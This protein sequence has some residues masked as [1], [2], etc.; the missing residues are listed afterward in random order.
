MRESIKRHLAAIQREADKGHIHRM[1]HEEFAKRQAAYDR[2]AQ[3]ILWQRQANL[4]RKYS[5]WS[6]DKPIRFTFEQ[7]DVN[8]QRNA[9]LARDAGNAAYKAAQMIEQD[10]FNLLFTGDPGTG[11]TSLALA[12]AEK[13][14]ADK[15]S[16]YLF[17]STVALA[18]LLT[19]SYRNDF[20][21]SEKLRRLTDHASHTPLL[22]LDDFG[23]EA[24][25]N[26]DGS[27][28]S[29]RND[30]QDWLFNIANARYGQTDSVIITTN[31]TGAELAEMY[32]E[33]II[34]R[35]VPK[36]PSHIINL[37]GLEDV[38]A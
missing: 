9:Q 30:L 12:I 18:G 36:K 24:K 14:Y 5:L 1:I 11:K 27:Y 20:T 13:I 8:R 34:S 28:Q 33:K 15:H 37:K 38:R 31:H 22:I 3:K 10:S 2:K 26:S 19:Q 4:W 7:W 16:A 6:G 25:A 29:V 21:A 17:I 32:D 23:T 35:L